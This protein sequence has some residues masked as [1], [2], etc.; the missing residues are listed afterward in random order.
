VRIK[1]FYTAYQTPGYAIALPADSPIQK[2]ADLKG[3][4]IG[5]T[6][7][8][9]AGVIIARVLAAASG[10]NPD[11]D[12]NLVVAGE[13]AQPVAIAGSA[14]TDSRKPASRHRR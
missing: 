12:I 2:L 4:T 6:N 11:T 5:V 8:A 3:K 13:G 10:L 9:S 1:N 14:V 7:M